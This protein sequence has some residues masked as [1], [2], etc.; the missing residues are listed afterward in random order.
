MLFFFLDNVHLQIDK[1]NSFSLS[2][3]VN[4]AGVHIDVYIK[5]ELFPIHR[6]KRTA[7]TISHKNQ[8]GFCHSGVH[9][10]IFIYD[11]MI[12]ISFFH[13]FS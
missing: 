3:Q 7:R 9:T 2:G 5:L 11:I 13:H 1:S 8:E 10:N 4:V 6:A 12:L